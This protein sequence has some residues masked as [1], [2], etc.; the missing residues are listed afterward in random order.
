MAVLHVCTTCRAG[1]PGPE[2]GVPVPGRRLHDALAGLLAAPPGLVPEGSLHPGAGGQR[3]ELREVTCLA[4]CERGCSA[5]IAAEGKW[6]VLLGGLAPELAAD[7]LDYARAYV[8]SPTGMVMPSR[9]PAALRGMVL[10]R[11]PADP[12]AALVPASEVAA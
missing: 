2:A 7:L 11:V 6:S 4:S 12:A 3:L 5:V 8:A 10:A 9:R 1:G